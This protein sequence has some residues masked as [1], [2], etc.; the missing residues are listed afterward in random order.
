M[1]PQPTQMTRSIEFFDRQ[2]RR[3]PTDA[4]LRLNPFEEQALRYLH[5]DVLDLGCG[6]GNLAFAAAARGCRVTALDASPA[7]IDHVSST[8]GAGGGSGRGR[9]G[10]SAPP[11]HRA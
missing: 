2:F 11:P 5:G 9:I 1:P 7:A 8:R 3:P 6:F 4:S 10:G